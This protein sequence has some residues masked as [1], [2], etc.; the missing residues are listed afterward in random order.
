[1]GKEG[2]IAGPPEVWEP[3]PVLETGYLDAGTARQPEDRTVTDARATESDTV[4][5]AC[6]RERPAIGAWRAAGEGSE[7]AGLARRPAES[8]EP[9]DNRH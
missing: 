6:P 4:A 3:Q 9:A 5:T 2:R 8:P 7:M 1:M